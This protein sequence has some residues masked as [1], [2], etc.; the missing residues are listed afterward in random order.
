[1][2]GR[3]LT[4]GYREMLA[5]MLVLITSRPALSPTFLLTAFYVG[6]EHKAVKTKQRFSR[7]PAHGTSAGSGNIAQLKFH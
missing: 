3:P 6:Q 4:F 1:M 5:R 2:T 7:L